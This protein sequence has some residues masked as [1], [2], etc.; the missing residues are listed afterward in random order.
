M[1]IMGEKASEEF[2]RRG[3]TDI[4]RVQ[5]ACK[6]KTEVAGVAAAAAAAVETI[7]P[8]EAPSFQEAGHS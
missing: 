7:S 1:Q 3:K 4:T 2:T 5:N 8:A 6:K